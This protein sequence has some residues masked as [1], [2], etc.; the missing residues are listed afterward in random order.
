LN[1]TYEVDLNHDGTIDF[2]GNSNTF[3]GQIGLGT[4]WIKWYLEDG[5][6]NVTSCNYEFTVA[7]C[8]NPT[9]YC[10]NGIA[11]D[12][13][14]HT[15]T[16]ETWATDLD[17]GS[18]DNCGIA[19]YRIHSPSL[20]AGQE[21]PP[22]GSTDFIIFDCEDIGTQTV[23]LW[24]LDIHGNWAYCSTYVVIQDNNFACS[25]PEVSIS[26]M[27]TNENGIGLSN[28]SLHITGSENLTIETAEDGRFDI[29]E[30]E[31]GGNYT[32][33]PKKDI[34]YLNGVSTFDLVKISRHILGMEALDSPYKLI[35]ADANN[36]GS[37][38]T[39]DIVNLRKLILQ[40]THDLPASESWRFV[41]ADFIFPNSTNPFQTSFPEAI[42]F[43]GLDT[44][45]LANFVAIKVGDVNGNANP[46]NFAE[47][48]EQRTMESLALKVE[49]QM[50]VAGEEFDVPIK[51]ADFE[52][53]NG[54]QFA[55]EFDSDKISFLD[56]NPQAL[57]SFDESNYHLQLS[58]TGKLLLSWHQA[59]SISLEKEAILFEL[60]FK[61][62]KAIKLSEVLKMETNILASEI[63]Q[64]NLNKSVKILQID[65]QYSV[66]KSNFESLTNGT[67]LLEQ[68]TPNP[69]RLQTQIPFYLPNAAPV[70][71]RVFDSS[72]REIWSHSARFD[73]GKHHIVLNAAELNYTGLLYYKIETGDTQATRKMIIIE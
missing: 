1:Y 65:L 72:G 56:V 43:N 42:A 24:I 34:N 9:P 30:L 61:S 17:A 12:L 64:E 6:G 16:I 48:S 11:L 40:L 46:G 36:S 15:G 59:Q 32:L 31:A 13:M 62:K 73:Q 50:L 26:G 23:D 68:N 67:V 63:Y 35:A 33:T 2:T 49:D 27:I 3:Q 57:K 4:H 44:D 21:T 38:T 45:V 60:R 25:S 58:K 20:G 37:I 19:A 10:L 5:C 39:F 54:F 29:P 8:K 18:Y 47:D 71:L 55:L 66:E 53:I 41:E 52:R 7:D 70:R 51:L 28:T 14:E 22:V 69:F